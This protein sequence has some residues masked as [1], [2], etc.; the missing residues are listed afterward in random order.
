MAAKHTA[1]AVVVA[2]LAGCGGDEGPTGPSG[3]LIPVP[4]T[5]L[6]ANLYGTYQGGLYPGGSNQMPAAHAAEGLRRARLVQP[7]DVNGVPAADG[8]IV[9]L[10]IGM[11]NTSQE[12]CAAAS[13]TECE[14]WSFVGQAR[15]APELN[16]RVTF[17]NGARGGATTASWQSPT[18]PDYDRIRDQGLGQ[19][20]LSEKQVQ[21]IW[22]KLATAGPTTALPFESADAFQ[23]TNGLAAVARALHQRYP[24]LRQV[25]ASSRSYGGFATTI[26]NPEPFAYQSGFAVKWL[27]ESQI[28]QMS[29]GGTVDGVSTGSLDYNTTAPWLTW[30][31]Y[32]WAAEANAIR[33]DGFYYDR[34]DFEADGTHPSQLGE[35]KIGGLM[36]HFFVNAEAARCWF[37]VGVTC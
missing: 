19:R 34:N 11:S 28:R 23:L 6:G 30:G 27:I 20:G 24:N 35:Q 26:L 33:S 36:L 32:L 25:F 17:I 9:F 8:H 37:V 21:V 15:A 12:F 3:V 18:A 1:L 16:P 10:S 7:L 31:P 2:L 29:G 5:D 4:L 22:L 14:E 13:F